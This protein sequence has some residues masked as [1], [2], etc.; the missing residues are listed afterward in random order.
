[1]HARQ[2]L[3]AAFTTGTRVYN[4]ETYYYLREGSPEWMIDAVCEA[5]NGAMPHDWIWRAC[6]HAADTLADL[7]GDDDASDAAHEWA[8]GYTDVAY[9]ALARWLADVPGAWDACAEARAEFGPTDSLAEDLMSGQCTLLE[10]IFL[11][12]AEACEEQEP[13]PD[14]YV[15][16]DCALYIA[17]GDVA[18][19]DPSW[20]ADNISGDWAISSDHG[21]EFSWSPCDACGSTLGGAR[22]G[23]FLMGGDA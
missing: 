9:H 16:T 7:D 3:A 21:E 17:N 8:D 12:L 2:K 11:T 22:M 5:R 14:G 15:C 20:S 23:A 4:G 1:M 19:P 18:E 6:A 13:E 10:R